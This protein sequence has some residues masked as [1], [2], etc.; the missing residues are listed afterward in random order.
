MKETFYLFKRADGV[1]IFGQN[2]DCEHRAGICKPVPSTDRTNV[3]IIY[4]QDNDATPNIY[5]IPV[6]NLL[7]KDGVPYA[8]FAALKAG[9]AG[10]FLD[11]D[12]GIATREEDA[13]LSDTVDLDSYG[14]I[15][16]TLLAGTIKY[17]TVAGNVRT[18]AF[19]LKE[20]SLVK[21]RRIWLTG[22][23]ANMGIVVYS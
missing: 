3:S 4:F 22:T 18:K 7:D 23:T 2:A 10:F 14:W 5:D 13:V 9:Y 20:V 17:T 15:Q 8:D 12:L 6:I 19:D 21:V 11:E 16:P 1:W